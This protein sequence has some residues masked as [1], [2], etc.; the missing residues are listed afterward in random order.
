LPFQPAFFVAKENDSGTSAGNKITFN[1]IGVNTNSCWSS[2]NNRFTAPVSGRYFFT[3]S[4]LNTGTSPLYLLYR[5]NG[6]TMNMGE[7]PR[8]YT[9]VQYESNTASGIIQLAANDY[10]E[11]WVDTGGVHGF[12]N[13]FSGY[14]IG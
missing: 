14:L 10:I 11:M 12:H 8:S 5:K 9:G 3:H 7:Y 6:T 4:I 13:F 2:A 1:Y